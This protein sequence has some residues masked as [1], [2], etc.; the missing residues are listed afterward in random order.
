MAT[1]PGG[2]RDSLVG[3]QSHGHPLL[4]EPVALPDV[5]RFSK[6]RGSQAAWTLDW[7][8]FL[9]SPESP[10]GSYRSLLRANALVLCAGLK[11]VDLPNIGRDLGHSLARDHLGLFDS[12]PDRQEIRLSLAVV[13]LLIATAFVILPVHDTQWPEI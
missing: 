8:L 5:R 7:L 9:T 11:S 10:R 2:A 1:V 6:S 12:P 13:G 3:A 4:R